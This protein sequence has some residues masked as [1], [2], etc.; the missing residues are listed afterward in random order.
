MVTVILSFSVTSI[1]A[2]FI[3]CQHYSVPISY[4]E[5][6]EER[7]NASDNAVRTGANNE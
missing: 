3:I 6:Y 5:D 1:A 7:D 2:Q 4:E